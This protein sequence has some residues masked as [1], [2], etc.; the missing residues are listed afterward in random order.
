MVSSGELD[1]RRSDLAV[2]DLRRLRADRVPHL[3]LLARIWELRSLT[4][5][6]AAYVALAEALTATLLT[7]DRRLRNAPA[8][9]CDVEVIA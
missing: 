1:Q 2:E 5:Y 6:D 3:P 7:A 4:A 8:A 9:R